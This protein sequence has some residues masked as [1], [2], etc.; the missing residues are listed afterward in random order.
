MSSKPNKYKKKFSAAS[1][2]FIANVWS[3]FPSTRLKLAK[4]D[5]GKT[6]KDYGTHK[7]TLK[8]DELS[9]KEFSEEQK[10]TVGA[11]GCGLWYENAHSERLYGRQMC[12]FSSEHKQF[13]Y[14]IQQSLQ[15]DFPKFRRCISKH[16]RCNLI[17]GA[18]T[19]FHTDR[20]RGPSPSFLLV[21]DLEDNNNL[22]PFQL[23][24]RMWPDFHCCVVLYRGQKFIPLF[25]GRQGTTVVGLKDGQPWYFISSDP[26]FLDEV[27][28][29]GKLE[30]IVA[31]A[32][33]DDKIQCCPEELRM[34]ET[35]ESLP[36]V[37]LEELFE[38]A[39]QNPDQK[40]KKMWRYLGSQGNNGKHKW[41]LHFGWKHSHAYV[42]NT[43]Y[44]A[45]RIH[46]FF[47]Y[48][49]EHT[50]AANLKTCQT[51]KQP[52]NYSCME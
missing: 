27:Q 47:R 18:Q 4:K 15:R 24:I 21:E 10:G 44:L 51:T 5:V 6:Y 22:A 28:P 42:P 13:L 48:I 3:L 20:C 49:R 12:T 37:S 52:I 2:L 50:S 31:L 17:R 40:P 36:T 32:I 7:C 33:K 14:T 38:L 34:Y 45:K 26:K 23:K 41:Q 19:V 46:V 30:G 1:Q 8:F 16:L 35:A 43:N 29:L 11:R 9:E 25:Q 39:E